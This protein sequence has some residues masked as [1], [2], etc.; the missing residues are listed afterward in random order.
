MTAVTTRSPRS[1]P[2]R[3]PPDCCTLSNDLGWAL[4]ALSRCYLKSVAAT[5]ADVPGGPRGYQVLAAA[6]R[7]EHGSQLALAQHL[8]VDR[9]VMTYL[10][11]SLAEAGL[12][13]RRPD[14]ADRRARRIVATT[15]GRAVLDELSERLRAAEDQVLAGLDDDGDR[16]TF[17]AL[18]QRL[19]VYASALDSATS[20]VCTSGSATAAAL[21]GC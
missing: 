14:P 1:R 7:D 9:T 12:I 3:Q 19:A 16:Q 6:A 2:G 8:G 21:G 5:F 15:R 11:D 4:G 17:R 13:E 18:L 10:L 20:D